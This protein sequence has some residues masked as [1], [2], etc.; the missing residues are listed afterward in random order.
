MKK[1]GILLFLTG[2]CVMLALQAIAL[3]VPVTQ[4][5]SSCLF[6]FTA[7]K[8]NTPILITP[9]R[10]TATIGA[11][12]PWS[13]RRPN[14]EFGKSVDWLLTGRGEEIATACR[15]LLELALRA[16]RSERHYRS[17]RGLLLMF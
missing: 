11:R 13:A 16:S 14:R 8:N 4:A 2:A 12:R 1:R 5:T 6:T 10:E 7:G 3:A 17:F 15:E 9:D